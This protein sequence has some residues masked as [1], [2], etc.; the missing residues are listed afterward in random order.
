MPVAREIAIA[1]VQG[2]DRG[3]RHGRTAPFAVMSSTSA[4]SFSSSTRT[5]ARSS[6]LAV[7]TAISDY[8]RT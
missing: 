5:A 6:T 7:S 3:R 1:P 8:G 4:D 2:L